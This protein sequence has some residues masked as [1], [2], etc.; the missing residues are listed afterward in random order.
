MKTQIS[1]EKVDFDKGW[2]VCKKHGLTRGLSKAEIKTQRAGYVAMW[3][4]E[5]EH[6]GRLSEE[7]YESLK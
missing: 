6:A 1:F 7:D 2:N 4:S 3:L 5:L